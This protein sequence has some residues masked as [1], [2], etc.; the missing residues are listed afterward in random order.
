MS[1]K[2]PVVKTG[3]DRL[4]ANG[5]KQL[6][7][8]RV[9]I[10]AHPSSVDCNLRHIVDLCLEHG[11]QIVKLFGPE[12]GVLGQAQYMEEVGH[13]RDT[14][15]GLP[16]IS[17]YGSSYDSLHLKPEDLSDVDVLL[18]DL[19]DVG[20]RY[21][22][23][24]YTI[25]FAMRACAK[26]NVR[27]MVIDRPNPIGGVAVEGG[28]VEPGFRS[29]VGE[30]PL[31]NRHGLTLGELCQLFK[32]IDGHHCELEVLW[33]EGWQRSMLFHNTGLPWVLPSPNMT[34]PDTALVYP[35]GCLFEGTNISEGRGTTRPFELI[36]AP[37]ID[38]AY[39]FADIALSQK[40]PGVILRP[41]FFT[42]TFDKH[43]GQLCAGIQIHVTDPDVFLPLRTAIALIYAAKQFEGFAWRTTPYEFVSEPIAIDLL[44][45]SETPRLIL[46][47]G[48]DVDDIVQMFTAGSQRFDALRQKVL[49]QDYAN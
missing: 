29:F 35:G 46:D 9:A 6:Q 44:F 38:D 47:K 37:Y 43:Q 48:G 3:L 11:I 19:Q 33:M 7:G 26:A 34:T 4:V 41:C 8:L 10:L 32:Q 13:E 45:G 28:D 5:F 42:P 24:C 15:T 31:A 14:R 40:L 21:Y 39:R 25:A 36:G 16:T 2:T 12:H 17:L 23:F 18:C 22:T 49:H 30:Y 1:Q 27:C 20:S